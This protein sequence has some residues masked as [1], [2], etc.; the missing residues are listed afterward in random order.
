MSIQS[1]LSNLPS[2]PLDPMAAMQLGGVGPGGTVVR[3][4][5]LKLE[6]MLFGSVRDG[7]S[8]AR[9]PLDAR[10][11]RLFRLLA[12]QRRRR[13]HCHRHHGGVT[14]AR[15]SFLRRLG[16]SQQTFY[17]VQVTLEEM[18][19]SRSAF[20]SAVGQRYGANAADDVSS[21]LSSNLSLEEKFMQV[22]SILADRMEKDIQRQ[23]SR[24]NQAL[25]GA[26]KKKSGKGPLFGSL[27]KT[28]KSVVSGFNPVAGAAFSAIGAIAGAVGHAGA[29]KASSAK[30]GGKSKA[31]QIE[32]RIQ[33]MMQ[34]LNRL[35]SMISN[36]MNANHKSKMASINNIRP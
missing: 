14:Q 30:T 32:T 13:A 1:I 31:H 25:S 10:R 2:M 21:I 28:I 8:F 24:W 34:R 26:A 11:Q 22:C 35:M 6:A 33:M 17:R 18:F 12:H 4:A 7:T 19:S 29:H 36:C 23:M 15:G 27:F 16:R 5:T 20:P 9:A 3:S